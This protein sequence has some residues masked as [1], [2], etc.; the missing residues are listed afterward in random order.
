MQQ[1]LILH[2]ERGEK[3]ERKTSKL[4]CCTEMFE[5]YFRAEGFWSE[6]V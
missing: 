5:L 1:S 2:Q 6:E 3:K 4:A